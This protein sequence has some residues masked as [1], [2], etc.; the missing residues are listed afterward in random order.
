[1]KTILF[2]LLLI[3]T[4]QSSAQISDFETIDFNKADSIA[5]V[6]KNETLDNL[7]E[8]VHNL[9][10]E[11]NTDVERFRAIYM[12]VCTNIA[13]DYGLYSKNMRKRQRF[14]NDPLKLEVWNDQFRKISFRKMLRKQRTIC[15]G[16]AYLI[17]EFSSL[18][19]I[20]CEIVQGFARTSTV[21]I[22][23]L[24]IP[25][26]SWNAVKLDRKWYLCDPTWASGVPNA[27]TFQFEF[28]YNDGFF[29]P[30]PELFAIN[31]Y[32][33][34][35]KW[36][37]MNDDQLT[38]EAFLEAPIFYGKAYEHLSLYFKPKKMHNTVHKNEP[39]I[40]KCQLLKPV[41]ASD[42]SLVIDDGINGK[43][44]HPKSVL[45]EN[46]TLTIAYKFETAGFYD[47]HLFVGSDLISTYTFDVK[48]EK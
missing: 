28:K 9:T 18:A 20:E 46:E 21:N 2:V 22:E 5:L 45:I 36:L 3:F 17:K 1:M 15:T 30:H 8:L 24:D 27:T 33:V 37:L 39:V 23:T 19:N 25:N 13:N 11:L 40:F 31:H 44:T 6:Y 16:Y 32:P 38:F 34:D 43:K 26:H 12:W 48:G 4:C 41:K 42:I 14:K 35:K 47:V 7:P 29:L 10:S